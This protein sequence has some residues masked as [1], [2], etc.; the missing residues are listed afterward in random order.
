[1]SPV[2]KIL[3]PLLAALLGL[4][5]N[6]SGAHNF[7]PENRTW[8]FFGN[9]NIYTLESGAPSQINTG[10]NALYSYEGASGVGYYVRQNPW[11]KFDPLGLSEDDPNQPVRGS[12]H[13]LFTT[14]NE[15]NGNP[16]GWE[17]RVKEDVDATTKEIGVEA[18]MAVV[19]TADA[20]SNLAPGSLPA[21]AGV[22]AFFKR[23]F[24]RGATKEAAS[25]GVEETAQRAAKRSADDVAE[26]A[27]DAAPANTLDVDGATAFSGAFDPSSGK[28]HYRPSFDG[29][30]EVPPGWVPR[31]GGH[32]E[33]WGDEAF[34]AGGDAVGYTIFKEGDGLVVEWKSGLN[35]GLDDSGLLPSELRAPIM[36]AIAEQTGLAVTSRY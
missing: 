14:L 34:D 25:E 10:G 35:L 8:D 24:S 1:M 15:A 28:I 33:V 23:L 7:G 17:D 21:K 26:R 31:K 32:V 22:K 9:T 16:P 36:D 4:L 18:G 12:R 6:A 2:A 20:V 29:K 19:N 13:E 11:S 3:L 27:L 30:G 5:G